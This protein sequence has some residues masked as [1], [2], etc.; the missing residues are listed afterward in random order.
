[1]LH[2]HLWREVDLEDRCDEGASRSILFTKPA[3]VAATGTALTYPRPHPHPPPPASIGRPPLL[4]SHS[5]CQPRSRRKLDA[6]RR[7]VRTQ[8]GGS[9]G[10]AAPCPRRPI[11]AKRGRTRHAA[12]LSLPA[13]RAATFTWKGGTQRAGTA[14]KTGTQDGHAPAPPCPRTQEGGQRAHPSVPWRRRRQP[15][16]MHTTPHCQVRKGRCRRIQPLRAM[17]TLRLRAPPRP[18]IQES[19]CAQPSRTREVRARGRTQARTRRGSQN[20]GRCSLGVKGERRGMAHRSRGAKGR[21]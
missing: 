11:R 10:Y 5:P 13:V 9:W 17:P 4:S 3:D 19:R 8:G 12:G 20:E 18:R 1:M 16:H 21:G 6:A 14:Q 7:P 2:I 15:R